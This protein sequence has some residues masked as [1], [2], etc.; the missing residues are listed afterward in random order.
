[1]TRAAAFFDLD[2][3]LLRG[4]SGPVIGAALREAGILPERHVPG[5]GVLYKFFDVVGETLPSMALA[6][7]AAA[8][9]SGWSADAVVAAAH[10]AAE[11][12]TGHVQPWAHQLMEEHRAEGRLVVL[13]TTTPFDVVAPFAERL[14]LDGV[15]ATRYGR[16]DDGTYD[17]SIAGNFVWGTGKLAAVR[18]WAEANDVDLAHSY[19]YSD[20]VYDSP[21]LHAVGFPTAVNPDPR[22][23]V[24]AKVRRWP[25][26]H[27]DA[28]PGVA[29]VVGVEAQ[30]AL[31]PL[32]RP[33]AFP[34]ARF[35]IRGVERV[36]S[37]GP[38]LLVANHRSYF[39]PLVLAMVAA[40]AGRPIRFL[41]KKEVFDAPVLGRFV[42]SIGTIEVDRGSGSSAPLEAAAQALRAGEVVAILPEG[43][44]PRGPAFFEPTLKGR[45]GAARLAALLR[46][47]PVVP[48]GLWGTERV[49]PR[50]SKLPKLVTLNPP[51][52]QVRVGDPVGGLTGKPAPDTKRMMA[53]IVDLLPPEAKLRRTPT[54]AELRAS[55]PGGRIPD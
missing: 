41:G 11:V 30:Q 39:D 15:V 46:D 36:P 37:D 4:A 3:T 47:V 1:M 35:D 29:K 45:S 54:E 13:A 51:R 8:V 22:L 43:T 50:S 2:R 27:L 14:G 42:R 5:E 7:Q 16:N 12:L 48:I 18:A 44:I 9:A 32:L 19:A 26:L 20:S 34:F 31:R 33:Q 55:Y 53:A 49:W 25:V 23:Q 10:R 21:L 40:R 17:G 52:V 24:V 28:P 38:V 6:R